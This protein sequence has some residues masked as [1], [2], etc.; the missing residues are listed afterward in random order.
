MYNTRIGIGVPIPYSKNN[1]NNRIKYILKRFRGSK[2][3]NNRCCCDFIDW[4]K[5]LFAI[6]LLIQ[7]VLYDVKN[8]IE[9]VIFC[10]LLI[11]VRNSYI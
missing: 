11:F 10:I 4:R 5:N 7:W 8:R 2:T 6:Y 3:I 9:C 1:Y